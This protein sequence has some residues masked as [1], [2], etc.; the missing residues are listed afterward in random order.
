[1]IIRLNLPIVLRF[2]HGSQRYSSV[3][4]LC[5]RFWY[6]LFNI[7]EMSADRRH[8]VAIL[9]DI[10]VQRTISLLHIAS[11]IFLIFVRATVIVLIGKAR[12][13]RTLYILW[14]YLILSFLNVMSYGAAQ[15]TMIQATVPTYFDLFIRI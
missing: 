5:L 2:G 3:T 11:R 13:C 8:F 14:S 4:R 9:D 15:L 6:R 10:V 1:M 7:Q 12:G